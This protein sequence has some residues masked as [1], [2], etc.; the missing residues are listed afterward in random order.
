MEPLTGKRN[1]LMPT[2]PTHYAD[3]AR[4]SDASKRGRLRHAKK[5]R[6]IVGVP[7]IVGAIKSGHLKIDADRTGSNRHR[8]SR[9]SKQQTRKIGSVRVSH[10]SNRCR[11]EH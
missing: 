5:E 1:C 6:K 4:D 3:K 9:C 11:A 8:T 2:P 7:V 10:G